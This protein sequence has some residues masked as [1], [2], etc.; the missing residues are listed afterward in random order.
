MSKYAV[1]RTYSYD[2][3]TEVIL[4]P[5]KEKACGYVRKKFAEQIEEEK[6]NNPDSTGFSE[7]DSWI[8]EEGD[9][10][11]IVWHIEYEDSSDSM[12]WT[13]TEAKECE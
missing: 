8:T 3:D 2:P 7:E 5:T 13:V 1:V 6:N 11:N 10:A 9:Y 12:T 4:F